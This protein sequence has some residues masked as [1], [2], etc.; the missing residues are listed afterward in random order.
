MSDEL[1][2]FESTRTRRERE[3]GRVEED[4][5]E[6]GRAAMAFWVREEA[7]A[8]KVKLD[9]DEE[10]DDVV[11]DRTIPVPAARPGT[12]GGAMSPCL[13]SAVAWE[14]EGGKARDLRE[15]ERVTARGVGRGAGVRDVL[16]WDDMAVVVLVSALK[17]E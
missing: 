15:A 11:L 8:V 16:G 12:G 2:L 7:D 17:R 13:E 3:K 6:V 10:R 5:D 4:L 14:V 9:E 1:L